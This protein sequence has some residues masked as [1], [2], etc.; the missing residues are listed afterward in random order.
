MHQCA[1]KA[2]LTWP[3]LA[4]TRAYRYHVKEI[5]KNWPVSPTG[6]NQEGDENT[7]PMGKVGKH[8]ILSLRSL[9]PSPDENVCAAR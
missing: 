9:Q 2:L 7:V 8:E 3:N 5:A 6:N 1:R 4:L